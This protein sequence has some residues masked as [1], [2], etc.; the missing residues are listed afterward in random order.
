MRQPFSNLMHLATT[1]HKYLLLCGAIRSWLKISLTKAQMQTGNI[2][3]K[4]GKK[5]LEQSWQ[6][7]NGPFGGSTHLM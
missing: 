5:V 2:R 1:V 4:Q 3:K 6:G 7:V